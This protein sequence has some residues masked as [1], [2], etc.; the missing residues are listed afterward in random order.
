[1]NKEIK[2]IKENII[3]RHDVSIR[4]RAKIEFEIVY[5]TIKAARKAGYTL[6]VDDEPDSSK[7]DDAGLLDLL[8][9]LD[10]AWL[11]LFPKDCYNQKSGW[12]RFVFG[13][14]GYDVICDYS[15]NLEF[16]IDPINAYANNLQEQG[17]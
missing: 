12:I 14:D 17:Y 13:N 11:T 1:M 5:R 3:Q 9:N 15:V 10:D 4:H 8:F 16:L 7:L 2:V 6:S